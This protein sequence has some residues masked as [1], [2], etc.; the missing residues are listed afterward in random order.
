MQESHRINKFCHFNFQKIC[1]ALSYSTRS[2]KVVESYS[3][4]VAD[5]YKI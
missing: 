5:L 3:R 2:W 1:V 4:V